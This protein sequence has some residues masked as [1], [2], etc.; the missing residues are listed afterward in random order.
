MLIFFFFILEPIG[1]FYEISSFSESKKSLK[2]PNYLKIFNKRHLNQFSRVYP[3]GI[4]INSSNY[5]P[6]SLWSSSFQLVALNYQTAGN[7]N[8][9]YV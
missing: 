8:Y 1:H 9:T 5:D 4:R 7:K 2:N 6:V 3:T